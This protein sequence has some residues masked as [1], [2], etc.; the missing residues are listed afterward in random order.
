MEKKRLT[1]AIFDEVIKRMTIAIVCKLVIRRRKLLETLCSDG[2]KIS[3]EFG[4]LGENHRT[5]SHEA[6]YQILLSHCFCDPKSRRRRRK[7]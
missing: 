1:E 2:C 5:T 6:V 4:I 7:P 3:F